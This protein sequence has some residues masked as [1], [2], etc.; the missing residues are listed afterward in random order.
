MFAK[1]IRVRKFWL[2]KSVKIQ[3]KKPINIFFINSFVISSNFKRKIALDQLIKNLKKIK[4][5]N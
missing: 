2:L 3:V 4:R 5:L 1:K